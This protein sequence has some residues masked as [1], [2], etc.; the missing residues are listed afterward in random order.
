VCPP[1]VPSVLLRPLDDR[2]GVRPKN[3]PRL[4]E[5]GY[6]GG[7]GALFG[8]MRAKKSLAEIPENPREATLRLGV[9]IGTRGRRS[10]RFL[11]CGVINS[12]QLHVSQVQHFGQSSLRLFHRRRIFLDRYRNDFKPFAQC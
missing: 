2:N 4:S 3:S 12:R 7:W 11:R 9:L 1:L 8:R 5:R 10:E 6:E